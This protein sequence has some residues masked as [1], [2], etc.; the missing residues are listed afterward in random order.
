[1]SSRELR[2]YVVAKT[3]WYIVRTTIFL[4]SVLPT[5]QSA[6]VKFSRYTTAFFVDFLYLLK[7]TKNK[8]TSIMVLVPVQ[9]TRV[10]KNV[11]HT[12]SMYLRIHTHCTAIFTVQ[13]VSASMYLWNSC[14]L[15][16]WTHFLQC[17][18]MEK[19]LLVHMHPT[20]CTP[21]Y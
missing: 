4:T 7:C 19:C 3:L 16:L 5:N 2:L 13:K 11:I 9:C 20:P 14:A 21:L 17:V 18:P 15:A 6:L 12:N 10:K 1:M 8:N